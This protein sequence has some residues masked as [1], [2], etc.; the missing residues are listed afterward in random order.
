MH[1]FLLWCLPH[2]TTNSHTAW[3]IYNLPG[4][5]CKNACHY[6]ISQMT[7]HYSSDILRTHFWGVTLLFTSTQLMPVQSTMFPHVPILPFVKSIDL[8]FLMCICVSPI[9]GHMTHWCTKLV[10]DTFVSPY[11]LTVTTSSPNNMWLWSLNELKK[12]N[13]YWPWTSALES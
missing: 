9:S 11:C 6:K 3:G 7:S 4:I 2:R 8:W 13:K 12:S 5:K 10:Q 1:T